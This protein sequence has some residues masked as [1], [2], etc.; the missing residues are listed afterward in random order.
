MSEPA[1]SVVVPAYNAAGTLPSTIRSVL[2]QT[3]PDFELIVVDDGSTDPVAGLVSS[4][5]GDDPRVRVIRQENRGPA[6]ARNTGIRSAGAGLV[7]V[8]DS[9]D[10]YMP[11]YLESVHTALAASP[12]AGI[13]FTDCWILN[14]ASKRIYRQTCLSSYQFT[15]TELS[16]EALL[17]ALLELNFITASTVTVRREAV[18]AV[19][20]YASALRGSEDYDL[21]L[22]IAAAGYGAVRP[23]GCH[24]VLRDR[25]G[26]QSKDRLLMARGLH[27]VLLRAASEFELSGD[28]REVVEARIRGQELA[29]RGFAGENDRAALGF[30]LRH[31]LALAKTRLATPFEWR[32]RP[33]QE[34]VSALGDVE[35]L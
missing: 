15:S 16:S 5:A 11:D 27:D 26:S 7:S 12:D 17:P 30:R 22:R 1:F 14:G 9:D 4:V 18:I 24:A 34:V 33:P 25:P 13:A 28:A 10:L 35:A 8:L 29:I 6:A 23:P 3:R 20:G 2:G 21:W 19:G 31:R 32:R